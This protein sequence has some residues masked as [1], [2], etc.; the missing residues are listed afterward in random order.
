MKLLANSLMCAV[1]ALSST[2]SF[3]QDA[4]KPAQ[5]MPKDGMAKKEMTSEECKAHMAAMKKD[6]SM[7][8]GA[9]NVMNKDGT[10][11]DEAMAKN[12]AMCADMMKKNSLP[13]EPMKK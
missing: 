6:G 2:A 13:A 8:D 11:R 5:G 12:D 7:K 9:G 1:I 10:K 3:A 4:A